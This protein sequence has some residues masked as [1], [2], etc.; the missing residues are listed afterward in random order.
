MAKKLKIEGKKKKEKWNLFGADG[1]VF[2]TAI[3]KG[4]HIELFSNREIILDGCYGVFEYRED[5]IKLNL[6]KGTLVLCGENFDISSFE[7]KVITIKG[8]ISSVEF[9]V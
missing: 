5:Y 6:G 8:K 3:L 2:D 9:C 4:A 7:A 1:A